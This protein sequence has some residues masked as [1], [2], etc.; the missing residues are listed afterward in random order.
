MGGG[1]L[2]KKDSKKKKDKKK[3][4]IKVKSSNN[5]N[6]NNNAEPLK[7]EDFQESGYVDTTPPRVLKS[8]KALWEEFPEE[9]WYDRGAGYW[10]AC[11]ADDNGML[12]G[13]TEVAEPDERESKLMI[14]T[15]RQRGV[16]RARACDCGGGIGRVTH[17]VLLEFFDRVDL[18][19]QCPA[20]VESARKTLPADRVTCHQ[21][22]LQDF[23][24]EAGAYD[25]IWTQW[26]TGHLRDDHFIRFVRRC[27]DGLAPGGVLVLKENA[28]SGDGFVMDHKDWSVTRSKSHL[29]HLFAVAKVIVLECQRQKGFPDGMFPV[30]T[31]VL[32]D[33]VSK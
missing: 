9:G 28:S 19:E 26:V 15:L 23:V 16:G 1:E 2:K 13:L 17:K 10:N 30:F 31:W 11:S 8:L 22:G 12:G 25:L 29:K 4:K 27:L 18:V 7:L 24:P 14:K 33:A 20:F 21:I 32:K 6:N 5:N 3:R